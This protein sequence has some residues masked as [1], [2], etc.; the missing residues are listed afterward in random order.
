LGHLVIVAQH[1]SAESTCQQFMIPFIEQLCFDIV[2]RKSAMYR[3]MLA[4]TQLFLFQ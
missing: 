2:L 1:P 3:A 4:V